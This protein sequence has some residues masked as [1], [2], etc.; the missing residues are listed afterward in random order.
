MS[1]VLW[2]DKGEHAFSVKDPDR[3]HF[4]QTATVEVPTGNSYGRTTYQQ[5]E[6]VTEEL[7]ICGPCYKS[8]NA[9]E[10]RHEITTSETLDD[11]EENDEDYRRGFEAGVNHALYQ[12]GGK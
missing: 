1:S 4:T 9:F 5:R 8:G 7:D 11:M 10:P 3:R 6:E 2:C 12:T